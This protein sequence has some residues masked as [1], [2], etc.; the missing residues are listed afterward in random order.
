METMR[1]HGWPVT[2]SMGVVTIHAVDR[3]PEGLL[4]VADALMYRVKTGG[5]NA[6]IYEE[7]PSP[8]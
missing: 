8:C 2:F 6:V 4:G 1:R 3:P 5:K 7:Y